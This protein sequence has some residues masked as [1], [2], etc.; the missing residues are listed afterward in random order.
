MEHAVSNHRCGATISTSLLS[1]MVNLQLTKN[2]RTQAGY[3]VH[4]AK[5]LYYKFRCNSI[6]LH[7]S[8]I[9]MGNLDMKYITDSENDVNGVNQHGMSN[10]EPEDVRKLNAAM[11]KAWERSVRD[12]VV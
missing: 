5:A 6:Q 10:A 8:T 11:V 12:S 7:L 4:R 1:H 3:I 2:W 9:Q